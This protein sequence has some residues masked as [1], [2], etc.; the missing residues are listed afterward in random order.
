MKGWHHY[1]IWDWLHIVPHPRTVK[2]AFRS[3]DSV[4][5][6]NIASFFQEVVEKEYFLV[7][8]IHDYH[9]IHTKH[10]SENKTQTQAVHMTTLLVKVFPNIKAI[11]NHA[12]DTPFL[13]ASPVNVENLMMLVGNN[14]AGLSQSYVSNM[15]DWLLAKYFDPEAE[16]CRLLQHDYQQTEIQ[17]MTCM[18]DTKLI[19]SLHLPLK[20][21]DDLLKAFKH[22][23]AVS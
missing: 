4:H 7:F 15:P 23:L 5:L 3:S 14:V 20:S 2:I 18:D 1:E 19:D 8:C 16:R 21:Y 13:P 9:N 12:V 11:S 22:M 17:R 10:R 6:G